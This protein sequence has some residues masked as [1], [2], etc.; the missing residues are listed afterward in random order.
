MT[1]IIEV[2]FINYRNKILMGKSFSELQELNSLA[3][4]LTFHTASIGLRCK[5]EESEQTRF[6]ISGKPL[7]VFKRCALS[8]AVLWKLIFSNNFTFGHQKDRL[9]LPEH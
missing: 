8:N 5:N 3:T 2:V 4:Q 7:R 6:H 1:P 9:R